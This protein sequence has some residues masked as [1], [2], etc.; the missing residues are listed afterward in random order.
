M[1]RD[2]EEAEVLTIFFA[3]VFTSKT[4]LQESQVSVIRK[5]VWSMEDVPLVEKGRSGNTSAKWTY[6]S[7]WDAPTSTK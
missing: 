4:S 5:K 7:K 6:I 1:T 3:L 2:M